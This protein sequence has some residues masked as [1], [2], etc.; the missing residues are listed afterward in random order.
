MTNGNTEPVNF[1]T[2]LYKDGRIEFHY[3]SG[4]HNLLASTCG[5]FAL[6]LAGLGYGHETSAQTVAHANQMEQE[7]AFPILYFPPFGATSNPDGTLDRP[8][9]G[10]HVAGT[11]SVKGT[12]ID[13][14]GF[15]YRTDLLIDGVAVNHSPHDHF[16][17]RV[18]VLCESRIPGPHTGRPY[19]AGSGHEQPRRPN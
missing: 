16:I 9:P 17:R 7:N 15:V 11:F 3:G 8:A 14:D 1:S 13:P 4:N 5:N 2:T 10:D 6:P 18:H 19:H 12:R